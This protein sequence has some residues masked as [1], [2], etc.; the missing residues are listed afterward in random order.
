[1]YSHTKYDNAQWFNLQTS[2]FEI[3]SFWQYHFLIIGFQNRKSFDEITQQKY[4][5]VDLGFKVKSPIWTT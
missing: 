4:N 3:L 2:I 5:E 1:M